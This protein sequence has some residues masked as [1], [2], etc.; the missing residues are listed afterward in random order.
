MVKNLQPLIIR[1][2]EKLQPNRVILFKDGRQLVK[3]SQT[4]DHSSPPPGGFYIVEISTTDNKD[5]FIAAYD[6]NSPES[7]L[8]ELTDETKTGEILKQFD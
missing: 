5:L 6:I 2:A 7:L 8:I 4:I 3:N 1:Q